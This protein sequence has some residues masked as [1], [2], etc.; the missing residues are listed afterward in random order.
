MASGTTGLGVA[1]TTLGVASYLGTGRESATA[2]IPAAFGLPIAALGALG[3][4]P[5]ARTG[6]TVL[7]TAGLAG[8]ARGVTQLPALLRGDPVARPAAIIAQS[9]MA[10]MCALWL[11]GRMM[12]RG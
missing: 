3:R 11:V 2:L 5:L 10:G 1:L 7:A 4:T 9:A 8:S 12:S 6:A